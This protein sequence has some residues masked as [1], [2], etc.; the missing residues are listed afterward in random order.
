MRCYFLFA[1]LL[2]INTSVRRLLKMGF[3]AEWDSKLVPSKLPV[4]F[5]LLGSR[6]SEYGSARRRL[7]KVFV[8]ILAFNQ[9]KCRRRCT[10]IRFKMKRSFRKPISNYMKLKKC[11]MAIEPD[12]KQ[13]YRASNFQNFWW[14][15]FNSVT[16][17]VVS[18]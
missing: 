6:E 18:I 10:H 13:S 2:V 12:S 17:K 11:W 14:H 8:V 16:E 4:V 5:T 1:N 3:C 15:V 7:P 9:A